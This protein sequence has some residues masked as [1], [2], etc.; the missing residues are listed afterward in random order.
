MSFILRNAI[1]G[2]SNK[3]INMLTPNYEST[4]LAGI[5]PAIGIRDTIYMDKIYTPGY[6]RPRYAIQNDIMTDN[7]I[8]TDDNNKLIKFPTEKLKNSKIEVFKYK[9]KDPNAKLMSILNSVG[10]IVDKDY[11]YETVSEKE[12]IDDNQINYDEDFEYVDFDSIKATLENASYSVLNEYMFTVKP[13]IANKY[14]VITTQEATNK[15]F[16]HPE[17]AVLLDESLGYFISNRN[18]FKRT[19]YYDYIS[20]IMITP[21]LLS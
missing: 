1:R 14:K 6:L 4:A 18:N 21:D 8:T 9:G 3:M 20:D 12:L 2:V 11:I 19:K 15:T 16:G 5:N 7:L 10:T 17:L 13:D